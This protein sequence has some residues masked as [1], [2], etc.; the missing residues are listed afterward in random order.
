MLISQ[1]IDQARSGELSNLTDT[2]FTDTRV[3]SYI[4]LGTIE[5]YKRFQLRSAEA[6]ITMEDMSTLYTLD[7]NDT[8]VSMD[9]NAMDIMAIQEAYDESGANLSINVE[10][11]E[12]GI[13]TPT[14]NQVQIPNPAEGERI[15]VIYTAGPLWVTAVTDTL[16]LPI[17]LLEALLHYIGYRAH[18][19]VNGNVDA[20][21]NTH[22][23]RFEASVARAKLLGLVTQ[24]QI[25]ERD[26]NNK[27]FL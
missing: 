12:L 6:I 5:L 1:V 20:E 15:G 26:V 25:A 7:G 9:A 18:G 4:N 16:A 3:L 11:D 24:D 23:Q 19:S 13:M 17:S 8:R 27:G 10:N 22:Y 21:N 14:F 2:I